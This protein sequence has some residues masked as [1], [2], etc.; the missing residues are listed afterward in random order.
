MRYQRPG[1]ATLAF[2]KEW[3]SARAGKPFFYFFHIF[4]PHLPY[5][6]AERFLAEYG[7]TYEGEIATAD[8]VV[9]E[10]AQRRGEGG[11]Q[12]LGKPAR[13]DPRQRKAGQ[14]LGRGRRQPSGQGGFVGAG[15]DLLEQ[16]VHEAAELG[17]SRQVAHR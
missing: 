12:R 10:R 2:A 5:E 16:H 11:Q 1:A 15:V 8:A 3:I 7:P 6:P 17:A 13:G 4:E 9:G 14:P